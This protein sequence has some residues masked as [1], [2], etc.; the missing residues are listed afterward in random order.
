M[1]EVKKILQD[2]SVHL[3]WITS[4]RLKRAINKV[5]A[6]EFVDDC[7][8]L[9]TI[10]KRITVRE[11]YDAGFTFIDGSKAKEHIADTGKIRV[12]EKKSNRRK[13]LS[14]ST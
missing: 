9:E 2:E 7:I 6:S 11:N 5:S 14:P 1:R 13:D 10:V 4:H 3:V 12:H 8:L